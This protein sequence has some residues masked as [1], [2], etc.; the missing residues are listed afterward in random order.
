MTARVHKAGNCRQSSPHHT[1]SFNIKKSNPHSK[2]VSD[3]FKRSS[4]VMSRKDWARKNEAV[5]AQNL[6]CEKRLLP[7]ASASR[8]LV[9]KALVGLFSN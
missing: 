4:E 2:E 6:L 8:K 9:V 5:K 7:G 3:N 1:I